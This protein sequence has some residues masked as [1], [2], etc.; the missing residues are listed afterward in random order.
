MLDLVCMGGQMLWAASPGEGEARD[1]P[2]RVSFVPRRSALPLRAT[3]EDPKEPR[4]QAVLDVLRASGAQYLDELSERANL[5][6][7]DTLSSLWRLAALGLATNDSFAPLRLFSADGDAVDALSPA[8]KRGFS[9]HDAALRARL[10][11]SVSGRWSALGANCREIDP[12]ADRARDIA[13]L[14]LKR[15]GILSR[16]ML[17]LESMDLSWH[18]ISFALRRLEYAGT[19]RRGWFVRSLSAE[20]Y[21]LPEAV[22]MLRSMRNLVPAREKPLALSAADPANPYGALLPGCGVTRDAANLVIIRAGKMLLGL[23]ARALVT[24]GEIDDESFSAAVA[25]ILAI[26]S[27]VV[28]DTIDG[29]PSLSSPRVGLLAAMRF[30]SDGRALIYDGLPGP[31]PLRA[32]RRA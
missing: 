11:S 2:A 25:A 16:E 24:P 22:E 3:H 9:R 4:D 29:V 14:L 15:N 17:A 31:S 20:Q 7:R 6:E 26:R 1:V 28:I 32:N 27:K 23:A 19:I 13:M 8:P 5:S 12:D 18:E 10:K 21:A 30:H